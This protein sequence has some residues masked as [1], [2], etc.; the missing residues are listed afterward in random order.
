MTFSS[1]S[2]SSPHYSSSEEALGAPSSAAIPLSFLLEINASSL[3]SRYFSESSKAVTRMFEAIRATAALSSCRLLFVLM[4]EVECLSMARES[5][6]NAD[7]SDATRVVNTLLTQIDTLKRI[8]NCM[9]FATSN[10]ISKIDPA[11]LDRADVKFFLGPP[12]REARLTMLRGSLEALI[13]AGIVV[14]ERRRNA[15]ENDDE[16]KNHH[17]QQIPSSAAAWL[18][19]AAEAT[20]GAS[21]RYLRKLPLVAHAFYT[22]GK[23]AGTNTLASAEE[24]EEE[25]EE[26]QAD[27]DGEQKISATAMAEAFYLAAASPFSRGGDDDDEEQGEGTKMTLV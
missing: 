18:D 12:H 2:S 5:L 22:R 11:F 25:G 27:E 7:P 21:G 6:S 15:D 14:G 16:E 17:Q 23:G 26:K 1:S 8:P 20:K 4:D 3:F 19:K 13:D 24:E 10:L 9:V